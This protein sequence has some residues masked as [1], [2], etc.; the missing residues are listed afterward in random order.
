[1][2]G[3][4]LTGL[5]YIALTDKNDPGNILSIRREMFVCGFIL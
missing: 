3:N 2:K 4:V 1:M 5:A